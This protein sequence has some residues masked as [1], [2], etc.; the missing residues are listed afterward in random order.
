MKYKKRKDGRYQ[1]S[2]VL[3]DGKRKVIYGKTEEALKLKLAEVQKET[4]LG[5]VVGDK[6]TVSE[7]AQMWYEAKKKDKV[8]EARQH[9]YRNDINN[10]IHPSLG[11]LKLKELKPIHIQNMINEMAGKSKSLQNDIL[12]CLRQMFDYAIEN[13]LMQYNVAKNIKPNGKPTSEKTALTKE[14]QT[15]LLNVISG[16]RVELFVKLCLYCGLRKSKHLL[17]NGLILILMK[18]H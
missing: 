4:V 2:Y 5:L 1:F 8:S 14:E 16:T 17:Y 7:W 18:V 15:E 12:I 13:G 10:H 11:N 3:P 6:T 9:A